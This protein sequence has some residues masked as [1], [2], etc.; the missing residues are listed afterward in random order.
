MPSY[1]FSAIAHDTA[2]VVLYVVYL[3]VSLLYAPL[4][5]CRQGERNGQTI[6]KQAAGMR[7]VYRE[8]GPITFGRAALREIVGKTLLTIVTCGTYAIVGAL[9]CLWD[10]KRQCLHDKVASTHVVDVTRA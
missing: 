1:I 8:G 3:I 10:A 6:G 9:W 7:V 5:M 4:L 2:T